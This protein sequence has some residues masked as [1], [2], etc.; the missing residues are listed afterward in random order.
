MVIVDEEFVIVVNQGETVEVLI[1]QVEDLGLVGEE[2]VAFSQQIIE[3]YKM[4]YARLT[5]PSNKKPVWWY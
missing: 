1:V 4:R 5:Y 2:E 3:Y